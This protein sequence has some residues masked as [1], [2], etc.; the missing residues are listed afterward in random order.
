MHDI[1]G[2]ETDKFLAHRNPDQNGHNWLS[3]QQFLAL[4][5]ESRVS[6]CRNYTA[7]PNGCHQFLNP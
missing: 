3:R 2:T 4:S 6:L 7:N 5:T 1:Q